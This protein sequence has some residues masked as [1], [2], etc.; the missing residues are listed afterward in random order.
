MRCKTSEAVCLEK[1][2]WDREGTDAVSHIVDVQKWG[3]E[4]TSAAVTLRKK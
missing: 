3:E 2:V 1:A 4:D